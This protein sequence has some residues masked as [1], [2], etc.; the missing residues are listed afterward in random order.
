MA[1]NRSAETLKRS[2]SN[3]TIRKSTSSGMLRRTSPDRGRRASPSR[4]IGSSQLPSTA[5]SS[6]STSSNS[7]SIPKAQGFAERFR[8]EVRLLQDTIVRY[9]AAEEEVEKQLKEEGRR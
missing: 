3:P 7:S 1:E 9:Q 4:G 6:S 5:S 2:P 8:Q